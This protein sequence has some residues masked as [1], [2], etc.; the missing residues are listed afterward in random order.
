VATEGICQALF[1]VYP[2]DI[3]GLIGKSGGVAGVCGGD[4]VAGVPIIRLS[5]AIRWF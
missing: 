5:N 2:V 3:Q 4:G 1:F